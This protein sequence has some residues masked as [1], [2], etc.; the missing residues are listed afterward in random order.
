ML[1]VDT[2]VLLRFILE[3]DL[4]QALRAKQAIVKAHHDGKALY[5]SQAVF[6][7]LVWVLQAVKKIPRAHVVRAVDGVLSMPVWNF[8]APAR[9][10]RALQ[11]YEQYEVD[12]TDAMLAAI[13]HEKGLDGV[14]SFDRD[15]GMIGARWVRP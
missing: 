6:Q 1:A 14:L 7:E 10:A 9:M 2:N 4:E 5:L 13:S 11:Y 15:L 8:E 12:F 3:D